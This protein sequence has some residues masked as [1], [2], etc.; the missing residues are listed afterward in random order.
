MIDASEKLTAKVAKKFKIGVV[1]DGSS[2][3][4]EQIE[5]LIQ[6][7]I[8]ELTSPDEGYHRIILPDNE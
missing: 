5:Q 4:V 6:R 3:R 7:E 8:L 1:V 2:A